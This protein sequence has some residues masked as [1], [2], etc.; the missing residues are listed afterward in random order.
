MDFCTFVLMRMSEWVRVWLCVCVSDSRRHETGTLV[1][2]M[3]LSVVFFS[4]FCVLCS[5]L[6]NVRCCCRSLFFF[7]KIFVVLSLYFFCYVWQDSKHLNCTIISFLFTT[8]LSLCP[9]LSLGA[10]VRL[11]RVCASFAN[12]FTCGSKEKWCKYLKH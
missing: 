8:R 3:S 6:L 9:S 7:K 10:L 1:V 2:G 5:R 12:I 11:V 4:L